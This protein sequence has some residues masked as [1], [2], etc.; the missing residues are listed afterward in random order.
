MR[1]ET[2]DYFRN[3]SGISICKQREQRIRTIILAK[4]FQDEKDNLRREEVQKKV[5][6]IRTKNI[7]RINEG[8]KNFGEIIIKRKL[9]IV[10]TLISI[11][12]IINLCLALYANDAY[13]TPIYDDDGKTLIKKEYQ[14]NDT[15][16][17][18]K[19]VMIGI[20]GSME[21]LLTYKYYLNLRY[22]RAGLKACGEDNIFTTKLH[23]SYFIE[24]LVLSIFSPPNID[25]LIEGSMLFGKFTYSLD[26]I[27]LFFILF[28]LYYLLRLYSNFSI[29]TSERVQ[30][31]GAQNKLTIGTN[32][33]I[34][35]QIK[36]SPYITLAIVFAF[37]VGVLGCMLRIFEFGYSENNYAYTASKND[38]DKNFKDY[39][40]SFWV[41]II[42]MMT[43]GY[44]DIVPN[45]HLG[46]IVALIA[47]V[48][49]MLLVSLLIVSLS[50]IVEFT[51][52]E[53]KAY[54]LIIK[55]QANEKRENE[56]RDLMV[57]L[58]KLFLIKKKTALHKTTRKD[59]K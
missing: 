48:L 50:N 17:I 19:W 26:S 44:G 54:N 34:K 37:S 6:E 13:I 9:K 45:T 42:T 39:K 41:I 8:L 49:G 15:I 21:V 36:N 24:F 46:R 3:Q 5:K 25:G 10:D 20:V 1:N 18:I 40:N 28:K 7:Q 59:R 16:K 23:K 4:K 52:E 33:A 47:N 14:S 32:F 35:A 12:V 2:T 27:I 30:L 29:W 43:V 22:L 31:I 56:A 38:G 11:L 51:A 55:H 58:F 57:S 53:K